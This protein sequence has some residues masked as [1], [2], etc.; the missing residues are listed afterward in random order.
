MLDFF[1][2]FLFLYVVFNNKVV[3]IIVRCRIVFIFFL[4]IYILLIFELNYIEIIIEIFG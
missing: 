2:Y 3:F 1:I 4:Y